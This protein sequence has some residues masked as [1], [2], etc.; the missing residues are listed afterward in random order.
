VIRG[1][2]KDG[3]E[4]EAGFDSIELAYIQGH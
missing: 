3:P 1:V 4:E 2:A